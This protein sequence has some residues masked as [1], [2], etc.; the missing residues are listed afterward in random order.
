MGP[1]RYGVEQVRAQ[2]EAGY[3]NGYHDWI[4]W[5]PGSRYTLGALKPKSA[6]LEGKRRVV[7]DSVRRAQADRMRAD[8]ARADSARAASTPAAAD[9]GASVQQPR[10]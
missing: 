8:S 9:S 4:L 2:I 5:N 6:L 10:Q 1:P 7:A 3:D